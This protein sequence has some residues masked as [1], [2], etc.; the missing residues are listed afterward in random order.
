MLRDG[1][2]LGV[3]DQILDPVL[4]CPPSHMTLGWSLPFLSSSEACGL[5]PVFFIGVPFH[6]VWLGLWRGLPGAALQCC[7][8]PRSCRR[9]RSYKQ[10]VSELED[11]EQ[12]LEDEELQPPRNKTPS[13]PCPASKVSRHLPS[14]SASALPVALTLVPACR[15]YGLCAPSCTPCRGTRCS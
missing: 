1:P 13:P 6:G 11:E 7:Y 12:P 14:L 5:V 8:P 2:A 4:L 9:K 15:W 10:A 3:S